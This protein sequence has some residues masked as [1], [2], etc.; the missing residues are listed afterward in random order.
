MWQLEDPNLG[1]W[2]KRTGGSV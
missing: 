1:E 2:A